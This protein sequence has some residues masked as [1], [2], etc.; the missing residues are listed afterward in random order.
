MKLQNKLLKIL[1]FAFVLFHIRFISAGDDI[2]KNILGKW[3]RISPSG[4]VALEFKEDGLVEVDFGNDH[5][6][7]IKTEYKIDV[8]TIIFMDKAGQACKENG[9]YKLRKNDFYISFDLIEDDC[10]GR[11]K[12]TMGFWTKPNFNEL[13][14]KVSEQISETPKPESY[15]TRARVYM[16]VGKS[17]EAKADLDIYLKD[18]PDDANAYINRAGTRFPSDLTGV[19]DDCNKAI[20]LEPDNKN[21][22]FLRGLAYYELGQKEQACD[23]FCRAIELG[24]SILRIAEEQRCAEYWGQK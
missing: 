2:E 3:V 18:K 11:I 9:S 13:L 1:V 5:T 12:M 23:D 24:F 7:D 20:D 6:I 17:Q 19:V 14:G 22:W 15:L 21:A 16:A 10:N 8:D 4:P